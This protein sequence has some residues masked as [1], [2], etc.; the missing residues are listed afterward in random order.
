MILNLVSFTHIFTLFL[1]GWYWLGYTYQ[2]SA[3]AVQGLAGGSLGGGAGGHEVVTYKG[4]VVKRAVGR[5]VFH[6]I[7]FLPYWF[8]ISLMEPVG[9]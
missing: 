1:D 4:P 3:G 7:S 8:C 2:Y 5:S 9:G 6:V